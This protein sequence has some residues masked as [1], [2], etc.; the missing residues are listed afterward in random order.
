MVWTVV[1][2]TA[3]TTLMQTML[4]LFEKFSNK[5]WVVIATAPAGREY[6]IMEIFPANKLPITVLI[7][8]VINAYFP[9]STHAQSKMKTFESPS[10][11]PGKK[12]GG[13]KLSIVKVIRAPA[14]KRAHRVIL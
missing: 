11:A 12:I 8:N 9:P 7:T 1:L 10:L 14:Q 6:I 4:I 2:T 3:P 13:N 5:S